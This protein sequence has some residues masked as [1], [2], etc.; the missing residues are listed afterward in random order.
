MLLDLICNKTSE[1]KGKI[2]IA[3]FYVLWLNTLKKSA[4]IID[5][6]NWEKNKFSYI[7]YQNNRFIKNQ[8]IR[9]FIEIHNK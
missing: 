8:N 5:N 7:I 9:K 6:W 3:K 4:S 1:T 2:F